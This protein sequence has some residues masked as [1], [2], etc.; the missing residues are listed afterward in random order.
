MAAADKVGVLALPADPRRLAQRLFHDR[1]G[2]DEDL[3]ARARHFGHQPPRQRLERALHNIVVIGALGIDRDARTV[4]R[5]G[6]CKRIGSGGI[7]HA[8]RDHAARIGPERLRAL[9]VLEARFHP[10]H[11]AVV[12]LGQPPLQPRGA[13][14]IIRR[15]RD[16][17]GRKTKPRSFG[18]DPAGQRGF[19]TVNQTCCPPRSCLTVN[20]RSH[21]DRTL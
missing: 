11:R 8:Q 6:Q 4:L 7:A 5:S 14:R 17:A 3:H 16:A 1:C 10:L 15:R 21:E 13:H 18:L 9:A 12:A 2:I 20:G 19:R